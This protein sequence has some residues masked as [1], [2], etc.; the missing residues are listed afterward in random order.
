MDLAT[1]Q[2]IDGRSIRGSGK[3][4]KEKP[5]IER[6][7]LGTGE[8]SGRPTHIEPF[9]RPDLNKRVPIFLFLQF[10]EIDSFAAIGTDNS[11]ANRATP[12]DHL[13]AQWTQDAVEV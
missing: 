4:G 8:A 7:D 1:V 13:N 9:A 12:V 5:I 6:L 10:C 3:S 2:T 11:V